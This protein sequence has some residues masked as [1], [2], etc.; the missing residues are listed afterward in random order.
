MLLF[1]QMIILFLIMSVGF[2][3]RKKGLWTEEGRRTLSGLVVNVANPAL[4]LSAS[5][6][7]E[8]TIQGKD[9]LYTMLIAVIIY[10]ALILFARIV[11]GILH[12][13]RNKWGTY[14][15]MTVFSNIGF[16]G[17]P[18]I[19]A[20]YGSEA[21]LYA[22]VFMLPYNF[23]IYTYGI[24]TMQVNEAAKGGEKGRTIHWK[25]IF[26]IGV[27]ACVVSMILYLA[28]IP[29][30]VTIEKVVTNLSNLTA[31]LSMIVIGD[32][33]AMM[34]VKELIKDMKLLLFSFIKLLFI[35]IIG[36]LMM[37]GMGV[38]PMLVGVCMVMLATP[39]GSMTAMLA[40]QYEG[41]YELASKGVAITTI[42][43]VMTMPL[44]SI[45]L[46]V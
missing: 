23:L 45:L 29:V 5:I 38:N 37:K 11:P 28:Q 8:A 27:I 32:S 35:P 43:S 2:L 42:L 24:A 1:N 14:K 13:E 30:P 36:V 7:K 21:L 44:V 41:D 12:V 10:F 34:K 16:M 17:F 19:S 25:K 20:V 22:S 6:N 39:V 18:V 26:N 46:K 4:I 3:C 40:Q 15:A 33:I 31:P 9:L